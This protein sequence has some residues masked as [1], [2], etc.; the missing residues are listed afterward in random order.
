MDAR[1]ISDL[2]EKIE[3]NTDIED[4]RL[5]GVNMWPLVRIELYQHLVRH[6]LNINAAPVSVTSPTEIAA[7]L[8]CP[9]W[10]NWRR[11]PKPEGGNV[12]L[13]SDGLSSPTTA[14]ME[15]DRFCMPLAR[16]CEETGYRSFVVDLNRPDN[17]RL[18]P[19]TR[20]WADQVLIRKIT[21]LLQASF[22]PDAG[23]RRLCGEV[24][25]VLESLGSDI[26]LSSFALDSRIRAVLSL[27][28]HFENALTLHRPKAVFIV[29][30]YQVA[31]YALNLA[32]RRLG[33]PTVDVQHGVAGA[34]HPAYGGWTQI[35]SGGFELLPQGF[36]AWSNADARVIEDSLGRSGAHW[37]VSGGHPV[38]SAWRAGWIPDSGAQTTRMS[39]LKGQQ[40]TQHHIL[41]TLQPGLSSPEELGGLL[42]AM[43]KLKDC[44]WWIRL[45][46]TA[47]GE[48][49][50]IATMLDST[51][52]AFNIGDAT[53]CPLYAMLSNVDL[54]VT[55]SSSTV[56]EA[57]Q[58]NVPSVIWSGYGADLFRDE[59]AAGYAAAT[60]SDEDLAVTIKKA[61]SRGS[62]SCHQASGIQLQRTIQ[63]ILEQYS[64]R[65]DR[66]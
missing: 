3:A 62:N 35:P 21:K 61:L 12:W 10:G 11:G 36:W 47:T 50:S 5:S 25:A 16:A 20:L 7:R 26:V 18:T 48:L 4:W 45:H 43:R 33:I 64:D 40:T 23:I 60:G 44:F 1:F 9:T 39:K 32:A 19:P 37:A 22:F 24:N 38:V 53:E 31:G 59:I 6:Q 2:I 34:F 58:F 54:H 8:L 57:A 56:I 17:K 63:V 52:A 42:A 65:R 30:Y 14:G 27:A 46:P 28:K 13:I 49:P 29:S 15:L 66:L 41:V 55:H 51:E